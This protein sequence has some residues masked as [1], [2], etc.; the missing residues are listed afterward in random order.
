MRAFR[1]IGRNIRDAFK[2]VFR[3][4][5]LSLASISAITVT[6]LVVSIS[7]VLSYNTNNFV[8]L[9]AKDV[10]IVVFLE[11]DTNEEDISRIEEDINRVHGIESYQFKDKMEVTE[12]Y[13]ATSEVLK[14]IMENWTEEDN[15]LQHTFLVKVNDINDIG[16]IAEKINDIKGVSIV[17]YGKGMVE[18]LMGIFE[19]VKQISVGMVIAL[20]LVTAFLIS[21]TIKITIFSRKKEIE[22]MRLV[23]ASNFNIKTPFV[24]EGLLLGLIGSII[25]I[26]IT[27]YGYVALYKNFD[28]AVISPFLKLVQPTPF[29]YYVSGILIVIGMLVGMFGSWRAVRKYLKI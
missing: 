20:I 9:I 21:N 1:I 8:D 3:N 29:I 28:L 2:S 25:P 17:N 10:T 26:I 16:K 22:I 24:F 7:I 15:P 12:E 23:G 14:K 13:M 27:T 19:V 11:N 18:Q 5:S 6:L 4:F